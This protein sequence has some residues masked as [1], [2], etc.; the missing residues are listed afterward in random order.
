MTSLVRAGITFYVEYRNSDICC[1]RS[2]ILSLTT[3]VK[4]SC[5]FLTLIFAVLLFIEQVD[6]VFPPIPSL[7]HCQ[8]AIV[9]RSV[10]A[11]LDLLPTAR[12]HLPMCQISLQYLY[13]ELSRKYVKYYAF[14][15]FLL[16]CPVLSLL[17]L[18]LS[19]LRPGRTPGRILT[20]YGLNYAS[21]PKNVTFRGLDDDPEY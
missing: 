21:S 20:I 7:L 4:L 8:F 3:V 5:K 13:G 16:S 6:H 17:Y 14:V 15:T 19:Q 10:V 11:T 12:E 18:F 2:V 1:F 9:S